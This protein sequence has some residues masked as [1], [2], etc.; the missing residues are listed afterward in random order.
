MPVCAQ[1]L[2]YD[3]GGYHGISSEAAYSSQ[4]V[5]SISK[6]TG[7]DS[8]F[9]DAY[10]VLTN[11]SEI[12]KITEDGT[13]TFQMM[14]NDTTHMFTLLQEGDYVPAQQVNNTAYDAENADRFALDGKTL[15]MDTAFQMS[16]Y[17][18][19]MASMLRLGEWFDYL[20]EQGV[21]D[22]TKIILVSDHAYPQGQTKELFMELPNRNVDVSGYFPLLMVKDF[23]AE[24]F[25]TSHAFMTHADVPTLAVKDLIENP[26]NPFTNKVITDAE[27]TAHDQF[28]TMSY[29]SD[30]NKN[31]GTTFMPSAWLSVKDN[32]WNKENWTYI[33]GDVTLS[34]HAVP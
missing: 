10:N 18:V 27:K 32:I 12:T 9:M 14:S 13:N 31:N 5:H 21:Y 17:H 7:I 16:H 19:N 1:T 6:S 26:V 2:V 11:M 30:V 23:G 24:G 34:K 22:N 15:K 33:S 8:G 29:E 25:T 4:I 28:I 3:N 20:R